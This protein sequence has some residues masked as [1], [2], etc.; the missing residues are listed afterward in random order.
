[1][2]SDYDVHPS[3]NPLH[4][5]FYIIL[6]TQVKLNS[7]TWLFQE[8]HMSV[9]KEVVQTDKMRSPYHYTLTLVNK[10]DPNLICKIRYYLDDQLKFNHMAHQK[11]IQRQGSERIVLSDV[12]LDETTVLIADDPLF[13]FHE[14]KE[15]AKLGAIRLNELMLMKAQD[16]LEL[17]NQINTIDTRIRSYLLDTNAIK[18]N[19][20]IREKVIALITHYIALLSQQSK[21]TDNARTSSNH[22]LFSLLRLVQSMSSQLPEISIVDELFLEDEIEECRPVAVVSHHT[23]PVI[24]S[25]QLIEQ[26]LVEI[27]ELESKTDIAHLISLN[28]HLEKISHELLI[29]E[30]SHHTSEDTLFLS[31]IRAQLPSN[32]SNLADYFKQMVMQGNLTMV[33]AIYQQIDLKINYIELFES[34][35]CKIESNKSF[36]LT[37]A[38]IDVA[39]YFYHSSELYRTYVLFKLAHFEYATTFKISGQEI[40]M[41]ILGQMMASNNFK[42][43]TL[44]LDQ[45][46][47]VD[48]YH[49]KHGRLAFNALQTLFFVHSGDLNPYIQELFSH[50]AT[51]NCPRIIVPPIVFSISEKPSA[52]NAASQYKISEVVHHMISGS[53]S[54]KAQAQPVPFLRTFEEAH[55]TE[56]VLE[57]AWKTCQFSDPMLLKTITCFSDMKTCFLEL[58]SMLNQDCFLIAIIPAFEGGL[59]FHLSEKDKTNVATQSMN[60]IRSDSM[61][62]MA[63]SE[64]GSDLLVKDSYCQNKTIRGYITANP[65]HHNKEKCIESAQYLFDHF[66]ALFSTLTDDKKREFVTSIQRMAVSMSIQSPINHKEVAK[67]YLGAII[68]LSMLN[69]MYV[70]DYQRLFKLLYQYGKHVDPIFTGTNVLG[71]ISNNMQILVDFTGPIIAPLLLTDTPLFSPAVMNSL[72]KSAPLR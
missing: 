15:H 50:G 33:S 25:K 70:Q 64:V 44:Y 41:T 13:T 5:A 30:F 49:A 17:L 72:S 7:E 46:A 18:M 1:M 56:N 26:L 65:H 40:H 28:E 29:Y 16:Q 68:G 42:A 69:S 54:I 35:L 38:L 61:L 48:A 31:S 23:E 4:Q 20:L 39:S 45:G 2:L 32:V 63:F 52:R 67:W 66:S 27:I 8:Q 51:L 24:T 43:F 60:K 11:I 9:E 59:S 55:R 47:Q 14:I 3:H 22:V 12:S 6:P 37:D 58:L 57:L 62:Y 34:L 53:K 21:Y 71:E 10:S 36:E 19:P